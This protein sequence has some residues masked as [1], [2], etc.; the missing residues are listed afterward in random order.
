MVIFTMSELLQCV[1]SLNRSDLQSVVNAVNQRN[2]QLINM[3]ASNVTD[4][5]R[6]GDAVWFDS[7]R[8]GVFYG[9][10]KKINPKTVIVTTDDGGEWKV[11]NSII[12][13]AAKVVELKNWC[14]W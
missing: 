7:G 4:D 2:T 9:T 10:V 8:R 14:R 3:T 6:V 5:L 12:Q 1:Q 13:R 11:H